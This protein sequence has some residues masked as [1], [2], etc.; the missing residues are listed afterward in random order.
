MS[1]RPDPD[2]EYL[3][4]PEDLYRVI[5][6]YQPEIAL[7]LTQLAVGGE[8]S[9]EEINY[10]HARNRLV[11]MMLQYLHAGGKALQENAGP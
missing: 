9:L 10:L 6:K 8:L 1:V 11:D 5:Q 2:A 3:N 7:Q 4:T